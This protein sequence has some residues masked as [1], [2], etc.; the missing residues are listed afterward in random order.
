MSINS[1]SLNTGTTSDSSG[2]AGPARALHRELALE[3]RRRL[4]RQGEGRI[5]HD[6]QFTPFHFSRSRTVPAYRKVAFP[7]WARPPLALAIQVVTAPSASRRAATVNGAPGE[8][9]RQRP[10]LEARRR[11]SRIG[12]ARQLDLQQA[13]QRPVHDQAGITLGPGDIGL[14]VVDA[15]AVEGERREAEQQ[16]R[17]RHHG[18]RH[19]RIGRRGLGLPCRLAGPGGLAIDDVV[20]LDERGA[21]GAGQRCA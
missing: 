6:R 4:D 18:L 21:L 19:R 3:G 1:S 16:H 8:Q 15:M 14:V 20:F 10:E 13:Q 9:R 11:L 12:A 5:G 17:V 7:C 2:S